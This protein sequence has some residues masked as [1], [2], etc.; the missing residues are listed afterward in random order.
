MSF[1]FPCF[2]FSLSLTFF[3]VTIDSARRVQPTSSSHTHQLGP[4]PV[5]VFL[6]AGRLERRAPF[7]SSRSRLDHPKRLGY[8][9]SIVHQ[10]TAR[11]LRDSRLGDLGSCR[12][13]RVAFRDLN[14][15]NL[16]LK[17]PEAREIFRGA[18]K[19]VSHNCMMAQVSALRD[20]LPDEELAARLDKVRTSK[21]STSTQELTP[22]ELAL[23]GEVDSSP[24][25][26]EK[27]VTLSGMRASVSASRNSGRVENF[28]DEWLKKVGHQFSNICM[29]HTAAD[30]L[31]QAKTVACSTNCDMI[32]FAV[33]RHLGPHSF[34][35]VKTTHGATPFRKYADD[36]NGLNTYAARFQSYL[37]GHSTDQIAELAEGLE[38]D[39]S[40]PISVT[41][42]ISR[43]IAKKTEKILVKR[44]WSRNKKK[45]AAAGFCL[46]LHPEIR[47]PYE[48]ISSPSRRLTPTDI[49]RLHIDLDDRFIDIVKVNP[50]T[51]SNNTDSDASSSE[52]TPG[53]QGKQSTAG[54][55]VKRPKAVHQAKQP[56]PSHRAKK[57]APCPPLQRSPTP[58][59]QHERSHS[60]SN[61]EESLATFRRRHREHV[62][63]AR[64]HP[65]PPS[66]S[67]SQEDAKGQTDQD[68]NYDGSAGGWQEG[69]ESDSH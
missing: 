36:I 7:C 23:D 37:T 26:Q 56:N 69:S 58:C 17:T 38:K 35:L 8:G 63:A 4:A 27:A 48:K 47:T 16:F 9:Y 33:S 67:S 39:P 22:S 24:G 6:P 30:P 46:V 31:R 44:P 50:S 21:E 62:H 19:G 14:E 29:M 1:I 66:L 45:L 11:G 5:P 28:L 54:N 55:Q 40:R 41:T 52:L 68:S 13:S 20:A 42:R 49:R 2:R 60:V 43:L 64:N 3:L 65:T 32:V 12:G 18:G 51:K 57:T 59:V 34:Q 15:W 25:P 53:P 10:D 61:S